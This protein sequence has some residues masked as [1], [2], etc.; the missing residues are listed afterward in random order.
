MGGKVQ[1]TA[2][3][4]SSADDPRPFFCFFFFPPKRAGGGGEAF[5]YLGQNLPQERST[6]R[7]DRV[8]RQ[9]GDRPRHRL[10]EDPQG[11]RTPVAVVSEHQVRARCVFRRRSR[12]PSDAGTAPLD[13]HVEGEAVRSDAARLNVFCTEMQKRVV[14]GAAGCSRLR[15]MMEFPIAGVHGIGG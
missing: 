6:V 11:V 2:E 5:G 15:L 9:V 13:L 3:L 12:P 4:L 8:R 7:S 14:D 1:D 10:H